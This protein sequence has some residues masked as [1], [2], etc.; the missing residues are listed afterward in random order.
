LS[1]DYTKTIY[2]GYTTPVTN[3]NILTTYLERRFLKNNAATIRAT[4]YDVFNQNTGYSNTTTSSQ[5]TISNVNRLGRY[6]LLTFTLRL[7]KFAGKAPQQ[8]FGPGGGGRRGEGG[9]R[10][11]QGGGG[12]F[13]G[14]GGGASAVDGQ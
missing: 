6:Y 3:P 2:T 7:Q 10:G 8:D 11:G 9:G 14:P 13:G 5:N 1:Y 4:V 12:G